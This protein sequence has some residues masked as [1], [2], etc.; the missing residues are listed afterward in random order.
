MLLSAAA[1]GLC[2]AVSALPVLVGI[3]RE[4][5]LADRVT[6]NIALRI[7]AL[8]DAVLWVGLAILLFLHGSQ[9][10]VFPEL[11][12]LS[13]AAPAIFVLMSLSRRRLAT[14]DPPRWITA[15]VIGVGYLAAGAWATKILGL[16]E[17]LGAYFAGVLTPA[18]IARRID[19]NRAGRLSLFAIAP[20]FFGHRGLSIDGSVVTWTALGAS[21]LL[22]IVAAGSKLAAL[23]IAPPDRRMPARE[24]TRLGLLL[25]CKG[26][27]EIV[28]ASILHQAGLIGPTAFAILVM[29]AIV[30]TIVTVPLFRRA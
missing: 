1:I 3:V 17:I 9:N 11:T 5:P 10:G 21:V 28:A 13:V 24:R 26:L 12:M 4:L 18:G 2:V 6:G 23:H 30:S 14:Y 25:Q 16:H 19:P 8:D 7:A 20:L 29:L 22:F 15:V 27:M